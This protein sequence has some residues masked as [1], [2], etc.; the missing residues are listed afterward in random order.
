MQKIG[1]NNGIGWLK[2]SKIQRITLKTPEW[3][4]RTVCD[5]LSCPSLTSLSKAVPDRV[6]RVSS[7]K[8]GHSGNANS[9]FLPSWT[10]CA[11]HQKG[12]Q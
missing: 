6:L 7:H 10:H 3:T 1:I 12:L 5:W 2:E 9:E 11:S 8:S 4:M